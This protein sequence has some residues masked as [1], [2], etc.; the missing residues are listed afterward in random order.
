M[1]T[2]HTKLYVQSR[3][4]ERD[5]L[6]AVAAALGGRLEPWTV[7]SRASTVE[8]RSN[9]EF[10]ASASGPDAFLYYPYT[11]DVWTDDTRISLA[12]YLQTV[13]T[14][15]RSLATSGATVVAA[16]PWEDR[17]PGRGRLP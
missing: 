11:A 9:D 14:V 15:M 7:I 3:R 8:I 13:G 5:L 10:S 16:C 2:F 4:S 17:L 6:G 1:A 12:D